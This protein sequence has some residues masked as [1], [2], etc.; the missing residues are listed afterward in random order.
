MKG[1]IKGYFFLG[2]KAAALIQ[3]SFYAVT[4]PT[5]C[6]TLLIAFESNRTVL[7]DGDWMVD[8]SSFIIKIG[9]SRHLGAHVN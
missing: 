6:L 3:F 1:T 4:S 2:Q 8:E 5:E 9:C 7:V